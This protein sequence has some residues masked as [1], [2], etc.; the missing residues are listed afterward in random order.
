LETTFIDDEGETKQTFDHVGSFDGSAAEKEHRKGSSARREN[1]ATKGAG[2]D[3]E[4]RRRDASSCD[5]RSRGAAACHQAHYLM[6]RRYASS[7]KERSAKGSRN[8]ARLLGEQS[9]MMRW[10]WID[11]HKSQH[12]Q[13]DSWG[14]STLP[15]YTRVDISLYQLGE[16]PRRKISTLECRHAGACEHF[17]FNLA[18]CVNGDFRPDFGFGVDPGRLRGYPLAHLAGTWW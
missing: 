3:E 2:G 18:P 10:M 1:A 12:G 7:E 11:H 5:W 16:Q 14:S 4:E 8:R 6:R 9:T 13:H 15:L 17:D